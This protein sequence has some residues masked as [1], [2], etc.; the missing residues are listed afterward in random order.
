VTA[1]QAGLRLRKW[2]RDGGILRRIIAI[3]CG[4]VGL[5]VLSSATIGWIWPSTHLPVEHLQPI[6]TPLSLVALTYGAW[7]NRRSDS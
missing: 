1:Q 6:V 5:V 7:I 2:F 4:V 3:V